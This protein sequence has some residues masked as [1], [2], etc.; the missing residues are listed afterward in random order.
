MEK[1]IEI[2][3]SAGRYLLPVLGTLIL[4]YCTFSLMK[5]KF[6]SPENAVL[7]EKGSGVPI[8]LKHWENAVGRSNVCDVV[9]P[10]GAV[11]RFHGVIARRKKGW[12]MID[13]YSKT[14]TFING[15]RVDRKAVLENGDDLAFGGVTYKF[16]V[17]G[18]E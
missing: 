16:Y 9:I 4:G 8:P 12:T 14:G 15:R 2:T 13:T 17:G 18:V 3:I 7:I 1:L 6:P 5:R 11:S 10:D